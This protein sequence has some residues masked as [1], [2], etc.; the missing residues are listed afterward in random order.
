MDPKEEI[1]NVELEI[2]TIPKAFNQLIETRAVVA[3][4]KSYGE[5]VAFA[6]SKG[7]KKPSK[8]QFASIIIRVAVSAITP[9]QYFKYSDN[10]GIIS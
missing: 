7:L 1:K 9:E 8:G 4:E 2:S 5:L 10:G 3:F 6:A